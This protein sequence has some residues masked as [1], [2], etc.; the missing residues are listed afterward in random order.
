MELGMNMVIAPAN[1]SLDSFADIQL[2]YLQINCPLKI[3]DIVKR[4]AAQGIARSSCIL[5]LKIE[6]LNLGHS[7]YAITD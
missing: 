5:N 2:W 1:L 7:S 6:R 3:T 4:I